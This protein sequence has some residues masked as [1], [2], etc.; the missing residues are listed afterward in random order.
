MVDKRAAVDTNQQGPIVTD[1]PKPSTRDA[2]RAASSRSEIDESMSADNSAQNARDVAGQDLTPLDQSNADSD[3]NITRAIRQELVDD[4]S[5]GTNAR[6]V[7]VITVDGMVTLRGPVAS[8]EEHAR[9]VAIAKKAAGPD[10]VQD[11]L[12]IIDR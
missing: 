7:K 5:L 1:D 2:G 6:N 11:E 3:V 4:D 12:Q 8:A 9:I 10:R